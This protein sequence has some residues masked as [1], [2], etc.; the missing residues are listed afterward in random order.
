MAR[1]VAKWPSYLFAGIPDDLSQ[2]ISQEAFERN[3][4][5]NEVVRQAVCAHYGAR[6]TE[7]ASGYRDPSRDTLYLRFPPHV[8]KRMNADTAGVY[9]GKKKLIISILEKHYA[10]EEALA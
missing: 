10:E 6:C 5:L 9:G 3:M 1:G 4:S 7:M 2:R 8:W